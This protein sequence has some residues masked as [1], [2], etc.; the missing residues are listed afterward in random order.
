M[1][2]NG[3]LLW[4]FP[5]PIIVVLMCIAHSRSVQ[6]IVNNYNKCLLMSREHFWFEKIYVTSEAH[7]GD[8]WVTAIPFIKLE[9]FY[10]LLFFCSSGK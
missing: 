2:H 3:V 5:D 10:C 9:P 1:G 4:Y 7:I 6:K 8:F